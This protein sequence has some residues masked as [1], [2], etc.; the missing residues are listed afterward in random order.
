MIDKQCLG[1]SS[2]KAGLDQEKGAEGGE[3]GRPSCYGGNQ[4]GAGQCGG[5]RREEPR[6]RRGG[7]QADT[8]SQSDEA[9]G[10]KI[11]TKVSFFLC[12]RTVARIIFSY[13]LRIKVPKKSFLLYRGNYPIEVKYSICL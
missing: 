4:C 5:G 9:L 1:H 7:D 10:C 3:G 12:S 2:A 13:R 6:L 8:Q 11:F